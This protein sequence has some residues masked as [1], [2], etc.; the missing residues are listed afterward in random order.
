MKSVAI[1]I[2]LPHFFSP[3]WQSVAV[4]FLNRIIGLQ[5]FLRKIA[6]LSTLF[7]LLYFFKTKKKK[8][9]RLSIWKFWTKV[10]Q[11]WKKNAAIC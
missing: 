3:F 1:A 2:L 11:F 9:S 7:L 8:K 6:T 4:T 5:R 10:W